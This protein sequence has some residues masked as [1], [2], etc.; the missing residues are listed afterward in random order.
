[1]LF[2]P[3]HN[4]HNKNNNN[5]INN[6]NERVGIR[7]YLRC[8]FVR[9]VHLSVRES[10][11]RRLWSSPCLSCNVTFATFTL[12]LFLLFLVTLHLPQ[13]RY[14]A[15]IKNASTQLPVKFVGQLVCD[16][17]SRLLPLSHNT[18]SNFAGSQKH[19]TLC[20][21]HLYRLGLFSRYDKKEL[22]GKYFFT[23]ALCKFSSTPLISTRK[24]VGLIAL[25]TL[26]IKNPSTV[27]PRKTV[28]Y[29]Y[30]QGFLDFFSDTQS[31]TL[32]P[33]FYTDAICLI[34]YRHFLWTPIQ[35]APIYQ[36]T[37]VT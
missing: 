13:P 19:T 11:S 2:L 20:G 1:M 30:L 12:L 25:N 23:H 16:Y 10:S 8:P 5:N 34:L 22:I 15:K 24:I 32:V 4:N 3:P 7:A 29:L 31:C 26:E 35:R 27:S 36:I 28:M 9:S 6:T 33:L 18:H 17:C 14:G 37:Y 21:T